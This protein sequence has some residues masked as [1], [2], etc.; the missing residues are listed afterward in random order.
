MVGGRA[1]DSVRMMH[2]L[3]DACMWTIDPATSVRAQS[4]RSELVD[5]SSNAVI[6]STYVGYIDRSRSIDR[7]RRRLRQPAMYSRV[8]MIAPTE[9]YVDRGRSYDRSHVDRFCA[10]R[11]VQCHCTG[12]KHDHLDTVNLSS[13][14]IGNRRRDVGQRMAHARNALIA[15]KWARANSGP[16]VPVSPVP[17]CHVCCQVRRNEFRRE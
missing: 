9:V 5:R 17:R 1:C 6:R 8:R 2:E 14:S 11:T 3:D 7:P 4:T 15:A 16:G 12:P 10:V 13:I